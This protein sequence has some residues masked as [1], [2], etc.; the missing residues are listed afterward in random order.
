VTARVLGGCID[1]PPG[2]RR[3]VTRPGPRCATHQRARKRAL[4]AKKHGDWIWKTYGI[5]AEQYA[6][7]LRYQGGKCFICQRATGK[8]RRLAVDHDHKTG[9]VR[10]LLCN[11]C[12]RDVLGHLRDS[13][14]ALE[15]AVTYLRYPPADQVLTPIRIRVE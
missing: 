11:P 9:K 15:R 10:G 3:P 6:S 4:A 13:V 2:S 8:R 12:N 5:T 7:M 14:A 1:C